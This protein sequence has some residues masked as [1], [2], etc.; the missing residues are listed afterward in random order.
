MSFPFQFGLSLLYAL[1]SQGEKLLSSG[2]PLEPNIG[3][4]ETWCATS[5]GNLH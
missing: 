1:L 2:V 4:F 5:E 3:D